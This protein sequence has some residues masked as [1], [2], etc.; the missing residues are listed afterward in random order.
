M[1][2]RREEEG[3][4]PRDIWCGFCPLQD[5]VF[6]FAS[7]VAMVSVPVF[8][9]ESVRAH[10]AL[11]KLFCSER[12]PR[13][14]Q[15]APGSGWEGRG[16][17][18]PCSRSAAALPELSRRLPRGSFPACPLMALSVSGE[19]RALSAWW[20]SP[21]PTPPPGSC[22]HLRMSPPR[23][24]PMCSRHSV[25]GA[26]VRRLHIGFGGLL[27]LPQPAPESLRRRAALRLRSHFAWMR[28]EL[29]VP[30]VASRGSPSIPDRRA[31][32]CR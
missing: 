2:R 30:G 5:D 16:S 4:A 21:V 3:A 22:L 25:R 24:E 17:G 20:P 19:L 18:R 1:G 14:A 23:A 9:T 28:G 7:P 31:R 26:H 15:E 10:R 29:A 13:A 12:E 32:R 11:E 8:I 27:S 6:H